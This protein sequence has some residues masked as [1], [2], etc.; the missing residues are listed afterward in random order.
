MVLLRWWWFYPVFETNP[1]Q[2]FIESIIKQLPSLRSYDHVPFI[3]SDASGVNLRTENNDA[4]DRHSVMYQ[5]YLAK[6]LTWISTWYDLVV[7]FTKNQPCEWLGYCLKPPQICGGTHAAA[8]ENKQR[9]CNRYEKKCIVH[10]RYGYSRKKWNNKFYNLLAF[11]R[12]KF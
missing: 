3:V 1:E 6:I 2:T 10:Q 8:D 5:R 7:I 4:I 11:Y 12:R 9:V